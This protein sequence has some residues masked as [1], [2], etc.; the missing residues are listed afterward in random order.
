[1]ENE[2]VHFQHKNQTQLFVAIT[3]IYIPSQRRSQ[4]THKGQQTRR[5]DDVLGSIL[6]RL[7]EQTPITT[8]A[9]LGVNTTRHPLGHC[10]QNA[11]RVG[12]KTL[13]R[14]ILR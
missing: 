12:G 14:V 13:R 5:F 10:G 4:T 9:F 11:R 2:N 6:T 1:M 8:G 3:D 7:P